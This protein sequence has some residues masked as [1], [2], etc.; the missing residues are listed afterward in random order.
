MAQ[1]TL[2]S[3]LVFLLASVCIMLIPSSSQPPL[4]VVEQEAVYRV[5]ESINSGVPWRTIFPDDM[6]ASAPHGVVCDYFS[7]ISA[8]GSSVTAHVTELSFGYVSDYS[9]NPSCGSHS[10]FQPSLLTSLPHL[11]KLFFYKCFTGKETPFPDFS[12]LLS[13]PGASSLEE[14]VFIENP[15]LYGS[16]EGRI[17]NFSGLRR[18]VLTGTSVSGQI[19]RG[20]GGLINMEQLTLSRNKFE[21]MISAGIFQ[22]LLKLK[23]LDL[24][25]NRFEG[26]VPESIGNLT[27]LLKLDLSYNEFSGRIPEMIKNLNSLEFLDLSYNR[28]G[29]FGIPLF[30]SEL[31][32]LKEVY[33]NGNFL[34]GRIP[35]TWENLRGIRGI[36]L[37]GVGLFGSIPKSMGVNLRNVCYLGLDNNRLEGIVPEE[38]GTLEFVTEL[39]LENNNLTGR[40]PF[41]AD[42]V[43]KLG[44]KLKLEGNSD[45]CIDEGL[46]SAKFSGVLG[47]LRVCR[48]PD[49][50]H[51]ALLFENFYPRRHG[52]FVLVFLGFVLS[53]FC[54]VDL[55]S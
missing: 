9:P 2:T 53:W 22:N 35:E 32:S 12:P 38:F 10:T 34:G 50:P 39:N 7:E 45:L 13:S 54:L 41:S 20:F 18:L 4:D 8:S 31:R 6:C 30:L 37:S 55:F 29:N 25:E 19:P 43:S 5:L 51:T 24:S 49:I 11:K 16:L 52:S 46:R 17:G 26:I 33:L 48:H 40:V 14:L 3:R 36:G 27:D 42:L 15:G 23:V 21:G 1:I 47:Q 44:K 28:F